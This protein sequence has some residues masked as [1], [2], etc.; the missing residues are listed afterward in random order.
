M[1]AIAPGPPELVEATAPPEHRGIAR[2]AVRMLVTDRARRSHAHA[3]FFDLPHVLRPGDVLVVNDSRTLPAAILAT[4][5]NGEAIPLHVATKIDARLWMAEPRGPVAA[6]EELRLPGAGRAVIVAPVEPERP[7]LW[8]AWFALPLPMNVYL[9]RYGEPIRYGYVARRFPLDDYQTMFARKPGSSEMPSAAR[10]FTPR[11][12]DA[13]RRKRVELRAITLHCGVASFESPERPGAERF[14]VS[15]ATAA[16][17]NQARREGRRVIAV[18]TTVL[19]ALESAVDEGDVV[20][21]SGWTDL[22]ID[23]RHRVTT[24][25]GLLTGFH[26]SAATHLSLLSAFLDRELL[27]AAYDAAAAETYRYHEFGDVHLIL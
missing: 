25:N 20:A 10:P 6:G 11:V 15:H 13:L 1:I 2:D 19:R 14:A 22:F 26:D 9:D 7:R 4:K 12:V 23:E 21:A 3:R 16:A 8:Y 24:A 17:V 18:G 27:H 5:A